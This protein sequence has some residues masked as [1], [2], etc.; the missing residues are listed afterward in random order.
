VLNYSSAVV[1]NLE[2]HSFEFLLVFFVSQAEISLLGKVNRFGD[3]VDNPRSRG[4]NIAG[5]GSLDLKLDRCVVLHQNN[6]YHHLMEDRD[7][8]P[9]QDGRM[10]A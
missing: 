7:P 2:L 6:S 1:P 8:R 5:F 3:T 9:H 4:A 10:P